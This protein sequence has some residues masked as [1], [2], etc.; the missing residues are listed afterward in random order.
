MLAQDEAVADGFCAAAAVGG[1]IA[2]LSTPVAVSYTH[3]DVYK[4]QV[5]DDISLQDLVE[6]AQAD[7]YR[8]RTEQL[9]KMCI[10][11]RP[12]WGLAMTI[13]ECIPF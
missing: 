7:L 1:A 13:R 12:R 8:A 3:L 6:E 11:D 9:R 2:S 10:R 5:W 4:R